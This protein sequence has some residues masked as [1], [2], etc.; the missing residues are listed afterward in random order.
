MNFA[1]FDTSAAVKRYIL[2]P[3]SLEIRRW[4]RRYDFLTSAITLLELLSALGRRRRG[5]E[6][7]EKNLVATLRR[8]GSDRVRWEMVE[9][10]TRVL[11]RA[12]TVIQQ[13]P[14]RTLDAI[15]IASALVFQA[16]S[17]LRIPFITADGRQREAAQQMG[18]EVT[19]IE[20]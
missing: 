13:T 2:E 4:M 10:S 9:T 17:G 18:L 12:E 3:G 19:W 20:G 5:G 16:A 6:F 15:H 8:I 7:S 1:Y 14:A 11:S